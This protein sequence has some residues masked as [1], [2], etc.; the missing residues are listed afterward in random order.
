MVL[1]ARRW[2]FRWR[3]LGWSLTVLH[4]CSFPKYDSLCAGSDSVTLRM[5]RIELKGLLLCTLRFD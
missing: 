3:K 4:P 1:R 5:R 2:V